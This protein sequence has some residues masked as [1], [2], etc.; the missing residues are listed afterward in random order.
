MVSFMPGQLT[1]GKYTPGGLVG[2]RAILYA[3]EKRVVC[4]S[5]GS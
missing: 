4:T 3:V 5:A 2:P 1:L